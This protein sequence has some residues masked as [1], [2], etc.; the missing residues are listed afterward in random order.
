MSSRTTT[1]LFIWNAILSIL[2]IWALLRK[3]AERSTVVDTPVG[4]APLRTSTDTTARTDARIAY[5][6]MDSIQSGFT[7]VKEQSDRYRSEG[8]RLEQNLQRE[9]DKAQGRY[10]ELM[11]KDHTYSTKA[12]VQK[13]EQELQGLMGK[14][15]ELQARSQQ[16][17]ANMEV[18]LISR[19]GQEIEDYLEEYNR[20]AGHDFIFSV[21][22]GGQIWVGNPALDITGQVL[23]GLNA[24]HAQGKTTDK[25]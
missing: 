4:D 20:N 14:I 5:F 19:I 18:E 6:I 3:P 8:R 17:L 7:L 23:A 16:Q 15:Q 13:D 10:Q 9:M 25:K 24:R 22:D 11:S 12:E 21:Q 2:L 1:L